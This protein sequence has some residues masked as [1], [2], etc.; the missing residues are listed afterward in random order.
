MQLKPGALDNEA[1]NK[2]LA[3]SSY[4]F[5]RV[6][7]DPGTKEKVEVKR[8]LTGR[9]YSQFCESKDPSRCVVVQQRTSFI[10]GENTCYI[11]KYLLPE[12]VKGLEILYVQ[13]SHGTES[14]D[15]SL[16]KWL[17]VDKEITGVPKFSSYRIS[18]K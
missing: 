5:T 9:E 2:R 18:L 17:N 15:L 6:R 8:I 12:K 11:C 7:I 3:N 1:R 16:P 10:L 4:G 14:D 13:T